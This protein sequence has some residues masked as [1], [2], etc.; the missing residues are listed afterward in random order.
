MKKN[1]TPNAPVENQGASNEQ[2]QARQILPTEVAVRINSIRTSGNIL[3]FASVNLNGCFAIPNVKVM[4]G[5]NGPFVSMPSYKVGEE[6]RDACFPCTKEFRQ[7]F[8][9][10]VLDAYH[11]ELEQLPQRGQQAAEQPGPSMKM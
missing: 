10:A 2:A 1:Q 4:N 5:P 6:H 3:A 11:Q 9:Q 8:D 7:Q